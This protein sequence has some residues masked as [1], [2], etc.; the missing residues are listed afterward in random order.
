MIWGGIEYGNVKY[1]EL[2]RKMWRG[3]GTLI[4]M[5]SQNQSF[6]LYHSDSDVE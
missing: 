2:D 5:D 1:G 4:I 3:I 6:L